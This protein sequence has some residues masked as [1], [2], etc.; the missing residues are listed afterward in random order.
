MRYFTKKTFRRSLVERKFDLQ[1]GENLKTID[2]HIIE[3]EILD[4]KQTKTG[5]ALRSNFFVIDQKGEKSDLFDKVK[6]FIWQM[7]VNINESLNSN[8]SCNF[9]DWKNVQFS[10]RH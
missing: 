9:S 2:T 3:N 5:D 7:F 8:S 6:T 1:E 4:S 10:S